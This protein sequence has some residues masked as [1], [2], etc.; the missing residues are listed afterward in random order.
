MENLP[1]LSEICCIED[2]Y[3]PDEEIEAWKQYFKKLGFKL[4][5]GDDDDLLIHTINYPTLTYRINEYLSLK[6][7]RDK[8]DGINPK[9]WIYVDGQQFRQCACLLFTIE[10]NKI[11]SLE[12]IN[13]IDELDAKT[14]LDEEEYYRAFNEISGEEMFWA[15]CSNIQAW[16]EHKYDTRLLHRNLAFP[17]LKKLTEAGNLTANRVFKEEIAKRYSSGHPSVQEYLKVE[18]YLKFLSEEELKL[19][20]R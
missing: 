9:V 2:F 7:K 4:H 6:L 1:G 18:G 12:K 11:H 13:S 19:L 16:V 20:K 17:L 14:K 8:Y 10:V 15:H 3:F 5:W